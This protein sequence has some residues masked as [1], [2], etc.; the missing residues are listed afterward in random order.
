MYAHLD[1]LPDIYEINSAEVTH[2]VDVFTSGLGGR[3]DCQM[4]ASTIT[5]GI[6][7]VNVVASLT[8]KGTSRTLASVLANRVFPEPVGPLKPHISSYRGESFGVC[9]LT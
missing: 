7:C 2:E 6:T 3:E 8:E 1:V 5:N 9:P 4:L